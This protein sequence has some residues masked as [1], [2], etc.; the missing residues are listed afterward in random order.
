MLFH[1]SYRVVS[2]AVSYALLSCS[3][4]VSLDRDLVSPCR[5]LHSSFSTKAS[6]TTSSVTRLPFTHI[7]ENPTAEIK[8]IILTLCTKPRAEQQAAVVRYFVPD[9]EFVH[10]LCRV[11]PYKGDIAGDVLPRAAV[12]ASPHL[13]LD[14]T[15]NVKLESRRAVGAI[16]RWYK[17]LSP[18]IEIGFES[19]AWDEDSNTLFVAL[20]QRFALWFVP[21]YA[22]NV[23]LVT[24]LKLKP[25]TTDELRSYAEV[26]AAHAAAS[27]SSPSSSAAPLVNG[28]APKT[29]YYIARQEDHYQINDVL[30]FFSMQLGAFLWYVVQLFATLLS[31]GGA[32][33]VDTILG[34]LPGTKAIKK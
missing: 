33:F 29:R 7:M 12:K 10:P 27:S 9:A 5:T 20:H 15:R 1:S 32:V 3:S 28:D 31:V 11:P 8:D 22:A 23:R 24:E 21:L 30:K 34:F 16:F 6:S 19:V 13:H 18:H 2:C 17:I 4:L 14:R 25:I 26:A